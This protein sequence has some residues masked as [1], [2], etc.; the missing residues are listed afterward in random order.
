MTMFRVDTKNAEIVRIFC[1]IIA[2]IVIIF[3]TL[4]YCAKQLHWMSLS[5]HKL[6][7]D[8]RYDY[9]PS[10]LSILLK[11]HVHVH[12]K[13]PVEQNVPGGFRWGF[14]WSSL[15]LSGMSLPNFS[16]VQIFS[17]F[18]PISTVLYRP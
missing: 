3:Y 8:M 2:I 7:F 18:N 5:G 10:D 15:T 6:H 11:V 14:F 17:R 12:V 9:V 4:S 16:F 1:L 13:W